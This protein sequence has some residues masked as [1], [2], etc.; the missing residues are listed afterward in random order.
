MSTGIHPRRIGFKITNYPI[1]KRFEGITG[2]EFDWNRFHNRREF[3]AYIKSL[4]NMK[5][6][7]RC[8]QTSDILC[9]TAEIAVSLQ[10]HFGD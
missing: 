4:L 10:S 8:T 9:R 1:I 6:N 3:R 5:I 2:I 7:K